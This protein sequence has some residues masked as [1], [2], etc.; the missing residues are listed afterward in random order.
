MKQ[1]DPAAHDSV[2]VTVVC[3]TGV[4][5]A[6]EWEVQLYDDD[7]NPTIDLRAYATTMLADLINHIGHQPTYV[8]IDYLGA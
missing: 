4:H 8:T 6:V 2:C 1:Y 5:C 7:G 3:E